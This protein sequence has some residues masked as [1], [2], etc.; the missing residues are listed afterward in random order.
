MSTAT[1]ILDQ[2]L[3]LPAADRARIAESLI[4]SLDPDA[5]AEQDVAEAWQREVESRLAEIDNGAVECAS[6]GEVREELRRKYG[7]PG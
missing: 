1:Q 3:H 2:A 6:W 5:D 4:A 7:A